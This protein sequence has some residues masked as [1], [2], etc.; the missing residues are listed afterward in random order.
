MSAKQSGTQIY[1]HDWAKTVLAVAVSFRKHHS[2]QRK[3]D[4]R[5]YRSAS[6]RNSFQRPGIDDFQANRAGNTW[7]GVMAGWQTK[8][9]GRNAGRQPTVNSRRNGK[10]GHPQMACLFDMIAHDSDRTTRRKKPHGTRMFD[11]DDFIAVHG[12]LPRGGE[13][14]RIPDTKWSGIM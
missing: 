9:R 2:W 7:A 11:N 3:H 8:G 14:T 6:C 12:K 4:Y 5:G 13:L 10:D 1:R